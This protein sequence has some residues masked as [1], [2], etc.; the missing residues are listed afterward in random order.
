M[1]VEV[2]PDEF[3]AETHHSEKFGRPFPGGSHLI[4][5]L[6]AAMECKACHC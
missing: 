3:E 2:I 4:L 1:D 5:L 6:P